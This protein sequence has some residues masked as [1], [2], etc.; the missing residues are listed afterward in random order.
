MVTGYFPRYVTAGEY[1]L[2]FGEREAA[3][4]GQGYAEHT[5]HA[6]F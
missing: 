1:R 2:A 4:Q 6:T 3:R 5:L